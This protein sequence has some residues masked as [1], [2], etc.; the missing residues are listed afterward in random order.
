VDSAQCIGRKKI[1]R[2]QVVDILSA[3]LL[4]PSVPSRAS[5]VVIF[6]YVSEARIIEILDTGLCIVGATIVH[7]DT[8]EFGERLTLETLEGLA[9]QVRPIM[10]GNHDAEIWFPAHSDAG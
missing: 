6:P 10:G 7:D 2:V 5:L 3:G 9:N 8:L 4:S 1:V